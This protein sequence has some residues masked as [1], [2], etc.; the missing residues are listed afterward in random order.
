[1]VAALAA[2]YRGKAPEKLVVELELAAIHL[3]EALRR[4]SA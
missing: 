4:A 2:H 3:E 1:M